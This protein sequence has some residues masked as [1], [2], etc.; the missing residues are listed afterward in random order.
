MTAR[1]AFPALA[2][3]FMRILMTEYA[4]PRRE[5]WWW[6]RVAAVAVVLVLGLPT[7]EEG[8]R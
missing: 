3:A 6:R 2:V 5:T 1:G 8:A 4:K 7:L